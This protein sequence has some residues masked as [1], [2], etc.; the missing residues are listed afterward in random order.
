MMSFFKNKVKFLLL[1]VFFMFICLSVVSASDVNSTE[2]VAMDD[3]NVDTGIE[4]EQSGPE[5]VSSGQTTSISIDSYDVTTGES[6]LIYLKDSNNNP[7][8]N[9]TLK[10]TINNN[11]QSISTDGN[12]IANLGVD[13]P[14]KNYWLNVV[15]EG[16]DDYGASES[17]FN[18][19][20]HK[21]GTTITVRNT[22]VV[23]GGTFYAYL[24]DA[25]GNSMIGSDVFYTVNGVTYSITTKIYGVASMKINLLAKTYSF[26]IYYAGNE[27]YEAI[28]KTID[29]KVL[30]STSIVIGN[31]ILLTNG[32]LRIYL[33]SNQ[34]NLISN[35]TVKITIN[36]VTFIKQTNS[37]GIIILVPKMGTGKLSVE[38]ELNETSDTAR[39]TAS[40][41][42]TGI[43]G[44]PKNPLISS[45]P[46]K[47]G[48]PDIDYM[49][50]SYV[51]AD[52]DMKYGLLKAQYLETIKRDSQCLFLNN[53]LSKY[54]IFK[55]KAEPKLN[56]II[57][58]EKWNVIERAINTKIVKA[59]KHAYWPGE[60]EVNLKGKSYTYSEVRDVQDTGYTCGP[61]SCSMCCQALRNYYCESY[62]AQKAGTSSA[63]GSST[64]GLKKALEMCN[65]KCT[66][67][68]KS[69]Y[70]KAIAELKKGGCVL[71]F[72][73]WGHY[74]SILDIS[75]DGKKVLVGNPSGDYNQGSHRIPTKWLT[76]NYMYAR[77][78]NY[79]TSGLI[80]K[81]KY[82]LNAATKAKVNNF[83]NS[84][85]T[86]WTRQ[87]VNERIPQI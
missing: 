65:F 29:L 70:N 78:N 20:V 40:K 46:L 76:V 85:G 55:S 45:I 16:D 69:S 66:V 57:K 23:Y 84:M 32:C 6:I 81:L 21:I 49:V 83:Y 61:T 53:M 60:I 12:G 11:V 43:S 42:V 71:V 25:Y 74:V 79:D 7:L 75:K 9:K 54:T 15:F 4:L 31:D 77:F 30:A 18:I 35:K 82:S 48:V 19:H 62:L 50:A 37:E 17:S 87:N 24:K 27:Y 73:T 33:K 63:Y 47:N 64:S 44:S 22:T 58:R 5:D 10:T 13:L 41:E 8:V 3:A 36:N 59:N 52:G 67:Y 34:Q 39:A 86:K 51:M 14:A 28:N 80:V 72:H 38:A 1:L 68:Y 56:H 2:G 26:N